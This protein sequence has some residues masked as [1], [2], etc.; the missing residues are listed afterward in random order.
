MLLWLLSFPPLFFFYFGLGEE[1]A[2]RP[3]VRHQA[4]PPQLRGQASQQENHAGGQAPLQAQPRECRQ[5]GSGRRIRVTWYFMRIRIQ[6]LYLSIRIQIPT[7]SSFKI[8]Y[9]LDTVPSV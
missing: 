3:D 9:V 8:M 2:G 5:V 1:Q 7:D 4:D 6:L